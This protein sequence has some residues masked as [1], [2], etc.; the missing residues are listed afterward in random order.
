MDTSFAMKYALSVGNLYKNPE[1][2]V[3]ESGSP[4]ENPVERVFRKRM[5]L[6]HSNLELERIAGVNE[7]TC[8]ALTYLWLRI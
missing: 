8:L 6:K 5:V 2:Q 4:R 3:A 7:G 1:T